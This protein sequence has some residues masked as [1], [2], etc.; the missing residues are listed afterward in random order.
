MR[1]LV[2]LPLLILLVSC[3]VSIEDYEGTEP[4]FDFKRFFNGELV[5]YGIVQDYSGMVTRRFKVDMQGSWDGNK[6]ILDEQFYYLGGEQDGE[7]STRVW[8][9]ELGENGKVFGR[10]DDVVGQAEGKVVGNALHWQYS[11]RIPYGDDTITVALD[12]WMFLVTET[13]LINRTAIDKFGVEVGEITLV[14]EKR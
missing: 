13:R 6:G 8:Y 11:L 2:L 4:Q 7:Q 5:A 3:S 1:H 9:L 12:D 10:A 14:I